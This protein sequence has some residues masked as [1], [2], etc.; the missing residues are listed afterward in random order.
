[1][2]KE[3]NYSESSFLEGVLSRERTRVP[4]EV[5]GS[6]QNCFKTL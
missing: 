2:Q 5:G 4:K 6:K 3:E 1:M